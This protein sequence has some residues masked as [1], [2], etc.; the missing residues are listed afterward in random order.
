MISRMRIRSLPHTIGCVDKIMRTIIDTY[1][2]PNRSVRELRDL[3]RVGTGISRYPVSSI[4][5]RPVR[6]FFAAC[7][8]A[9]CRTTSRVISGAK[10][11]TNSSR[12]DCI[13]STNDRSTRGV[14]A[15]MMATESTP[16]GLVAR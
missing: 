10:P 12:I 9:E 2:S 5:H 1:F 16:P 6:Q 15:A 11:I 14:E 13:P 7:R 3:I 8:C 4:S